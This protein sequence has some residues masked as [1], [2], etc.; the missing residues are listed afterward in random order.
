MIAQFY[1]AILIFYG[2]KIKFTN[3][4]ANKKDKK[5]KFLKLPVHICRLETKD[6][7]GFKL[8]AILLTLRD[9]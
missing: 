9:F 7:I 3:L 8:N 4:V 1:K 5:G 6:G 2:K